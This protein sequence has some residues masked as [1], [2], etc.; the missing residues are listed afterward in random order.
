MVFHI[1]CAANLMMILMIKMFMMI[2]MMGVHDEYEDDFEDGYGH[3][4]KF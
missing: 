4:G 1:Y 3:Y 2:K